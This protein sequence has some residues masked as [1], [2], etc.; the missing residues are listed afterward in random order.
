M[1]Q[2]NSLA[3]KLNDFTNDSQL[4]P[5][6]ETDS[7]I[8]NITPINKLFKSIITLAIIFARSFIFGYALMTLL[9]IDWK[10]LSFLCIGASINFLL[11]TFLELVMIIRG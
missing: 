9:N 7:S 10:F 1:I 3:D 11:G 2:N 4:I 6:D 8:D 5:D